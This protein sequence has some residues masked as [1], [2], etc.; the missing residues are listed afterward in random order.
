M[1]PRCD[2]PRDFVAISKNLAEGV[3]KSKHLQIKWFQKYEWLL[4]EHLK[5]KKEM[6]KLCEEK[7]SAIPTK[8]FVRE[9]GKT[10]LPAPVTTN[11]MYGWLASKPK[12]QLEIYGPYMPQYPDPMKD[13]V[14][15]TGD[16]PL[17]AVGKG[18][19]W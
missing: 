5:L 16:I 8:T 9:E 10:C 7:Q 6:D 18:F 1:D 15:L 2:K 11:A 19:I 3:A 13:I 17:L 4:E 12:F 14:T